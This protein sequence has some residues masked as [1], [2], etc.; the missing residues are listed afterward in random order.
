MGASLGALDCYADDPIDVPVVNG[1]YERSYALPM[2]K[3]RPN[4]PIVY[5]DIQVKDQILGRVE[6]ELRDDVVPRTAEN[7]RALCTHEKGFGFQTSPFHRVIPGFMCQGGDITMGNGMGGKHIY[8]GWTFEDE[9]FKLTH[10]AE[11]VL[12]MVRANVIA[13]SPSPS[14]ILRDDVRTRDDDDDVLLVEGK[15]RQGHELLSIFYM[16]QSVP[17]F[18]R[19]TCRVRPSIERIFCRK[20]HGIIGNSRIGLDRTSDSRGCVRTTHLGVRG[21]RSHEAL[22]AYRALLSLSR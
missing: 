5:L 12:S 6:I 11:G 15:S 16:H 18:E 22:D 13:I 2:G 7:F 3:A 4:N 10:S 1:E 20:G 17:E 9:N 14:S 8:D 19:K 21:E